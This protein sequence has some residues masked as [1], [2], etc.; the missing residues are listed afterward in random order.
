MAT[1]ERMVLRVQCMAGLYGNA[2]GVLCIA[3]CRCALRG[4]QSPR[5]QTIANFAGTNV[6]HAASLA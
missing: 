5:S 6:R 4:L 3:W 1:I 2:E